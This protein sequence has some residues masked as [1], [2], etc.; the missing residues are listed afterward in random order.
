MTIKA[1]EKEFSSYVVD[2]MQS[3]GPV[4]CKRMFGGFGIFLD[5]LMFGLIAER[6]LY[7]KVDAECGKSVLKK[8]G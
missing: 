3:Y 2:L 1:A 5:E 6:V 4:H 7:L 8:R